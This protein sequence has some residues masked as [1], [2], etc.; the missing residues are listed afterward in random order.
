MKSANELVGLAISE[1]NHANVPA[2]VK[3][4]VE[5]HRQALLDLADA[6]MASGRNEDEV[7]QIIQKASESF[8]TKMKSETEGLPS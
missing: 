8:S 4:I 3:E 1:H 2:R 7:V 6:L 5:R